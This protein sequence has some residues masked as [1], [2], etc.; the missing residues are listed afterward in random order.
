MMKS[1]SYRVINKYILVNTFMFLLLAS[2]ATTNVLADDS[3]SYSPDQWPR[4][5]N[6]LINK[7]QKQNRRRARQHGYA[8]Q[9][10][11]RSR[12]WGVAPVAEKRS[13]RTYRPE[14]NTNAHMVN[15]SGQNMY[16]GNY[17]SAMNGLGLA[18]PYASPLLVPGLMPGLAAPGIPFMTNS[19]GTNPYM[20]G[21]PMPG[22]MW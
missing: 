2:A 4:H 10:P 8:S 11:L 15:Y 7:T 18:N 1:V 14:Y 20:N 21:M 5:W 22:Y 13:R 6:V 12:I 17:Y 9:K 19:Y 16:R 3:L